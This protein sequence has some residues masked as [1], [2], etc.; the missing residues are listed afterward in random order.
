[1]PV[2]DS[3]GTR[4]LC[5]VL[6]WLA[7][8]VLPLS[9]YFFGPPMLN[10]VLLLLLLLLLLLVGDS[11]TIKPVLSGN[12]RANSLVSILTRCSS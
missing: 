9:I 11:G 12:E 3:L 8:L 7:A 10:R 4:T 2:I 6:T 1:M 5:T